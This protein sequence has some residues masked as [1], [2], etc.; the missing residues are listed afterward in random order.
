MIIVHMALAPFTPRLPLL[1]VWAI[2]INCEAQTCMSGVLARPWVGLAT[3]GLAPNVSASW[4]SVCESSGCGECITLPSNKPRIGH[5]KTWSQSDDPPPR[6]SYRHETH[7]LL[8]R[9]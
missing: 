1:G 6:G 8:G 5:T 7:F 9:L 4:R 3:P 2:S